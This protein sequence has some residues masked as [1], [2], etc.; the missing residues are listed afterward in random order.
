VRIGNVGNDI[1]KEWFDI[2]L[3]VDE[4]RQDQRF[5]NNNAGFKKCQKWLESFKGI[6]RFNMVF[7]PTGRYGMPIAEFFLKNP[8]F[9]LYQV[10]PTKIKDF[11]KSLDI[12]KSTDRSSALALAYYGE[13][14]ASKPQRYGLR[15]FEPK[16]SAQSS[17]ADIGVRL[18]SLFKRKSMLENQLECGLV[19]SKVIQSTKRE[20]SG[21]DKDIADMLNYAKEVIQNDPVLQGDVER[22]VTI[23]GIGMK[24]AITLVSLVDFR[25]FNS[26]RALGCFLGLSTKVKESGTSVRS[27]ERMS[28]AGNKHVRT[29]LYYPAM[30]AMQHN[31]QLR[32]FAEGLKAKGKI[33]PVIRTA[34]TRKLVVLAWT[35]INK[36]TNYDPNYVN[37]N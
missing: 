8:K 9:S 1:A 6:E 17:L 21:I 25:R 5:Q 2:C 4:Q 29:A 30:T 31:P 35:L 20:L 26:G 37:P 27:K 19:D 33:H 15:M 23:L 3:L 16:T 12:R 32:E 11:K 28:K 13:E 10:H 36:G 18:R 24:T 22:L 14:R 7:E 34:V